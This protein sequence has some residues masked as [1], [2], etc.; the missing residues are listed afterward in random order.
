MSVEAITKLFED[1]LTK[2]KNDDGNHDW[3]YT[4]LE[5]FA[6]SLKELAEIA[7]IDIAKLAS[8]QIN[9]HAPEGFFHSMEQRIEHVVDEVKEAFTGAEA[10]VEA[11]VVEV[12]TEVAPVVQEAVTE[13]QD[14]VAQMEYAAEQVKEAVTKKKTAKPADQNNQ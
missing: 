4:G 12:K 2:V 14:K 10:K 6:T 13:G 1:M 11:T 7:K 3:L 9:W 5:S 8:N